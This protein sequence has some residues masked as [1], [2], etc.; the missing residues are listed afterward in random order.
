LQVQE[1]NQFPFGG[2]RGK[3]KKQSNRKQFSVSGMAVRLLILIIVWERPNSRQRE[4]FQKHK[5]HNGKGR[6]GIQF[7]TETPVLFCSRT[8]VFILGLLWIYKQ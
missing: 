1:L 6:H 5:F 4:E 2:W 8:I 3:R 7:L